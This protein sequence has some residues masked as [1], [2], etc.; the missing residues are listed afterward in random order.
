MQGSLTCR[1][2]W[3][4]YVLRHE[5]ELHR[6]LFYFWGVLV[7]REHVRHNKSGITHRDR[8]MINLDLSYTTD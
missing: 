4:Q 7:T 8:A 1:R 2:T 3:M 5:V 6:I